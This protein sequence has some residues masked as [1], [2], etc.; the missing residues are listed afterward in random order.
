VTA[1]KTEVHPAPGVITQGGKRST[2]SEGNDNKVDW[3]ILGVILEIELEH[4]G[5]V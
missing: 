4:F 1:P 5:N 2:G 3:L